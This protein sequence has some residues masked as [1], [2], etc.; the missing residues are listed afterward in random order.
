MLINHHVV[1]DGDRTV[2]SVIDRLQVGDYV[3]AFGNRFGVSQR[4]TSGIV[5]ALNHSGPEIEGYEDL[6]QTYTS[7]NPGNY[8]GALVTVIG[9]LVKIRDFTPDLAEALELEADVGH[10]I[11]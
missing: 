7:I 3:L 4:V 9:R 1:D 8:G 11:I 6:I 2:V 10:V 5:S